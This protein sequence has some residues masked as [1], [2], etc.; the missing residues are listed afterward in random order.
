MK[1]K[2]ILRFHHTL[3]RRTKIKKRKATPP[4][5]PNKNKRWSRSEEREH[6]SILVVVQTGAT[7]MKTS[8]DVPQKARDGSILLQR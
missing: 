7:T 2:S 8:V 5:H 4:T 6:L 1:T 3:V